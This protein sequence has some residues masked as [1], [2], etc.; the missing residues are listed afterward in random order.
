MVTKLRS[1]DGNPWDREALQAPLHVVS[2]GT[3]GAP[4][5]ML[6]HGLFG[7]GSNL[8]ALARAL[9]PAYRVLQLDLPNHG[10][11]P[12]L[13]S[14]DL[15]SLATAVGREIDRCGAAPVTLVGHSL[16]GK[17]AM[18]LA[19]DAPERIAAFVAADI[20]PVAYAPGHDRVF[21]ALEAIAAQPPRSRRDAVARMLE[22]IQEPG[23]A[24]FLA[25]SLERGADE[26][27]HWRFNLRGLREGYDAIRRPPV[28]ES[29]AGPALFLYGD[30]SAYVDDAG[31]QAARELFPAAQF[32]VIEGAGHWLHA[33]QPELFNRRVRAFL[34]RELA[35]EG[36]R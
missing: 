3:D 32:G 36:A 17:V 16:G 29:Y 28:G 23:V 18:Q 34:D 19:L 1:A 9:A 35:V 24:Q 10:R 4:V 2:S 11:S 6:L 8:G 33:E 12:W 31:R 5:V 26:H 14:M 27:Y 20:A 7:M 25:L 15:S 13:E 30:A 22:H 21:A